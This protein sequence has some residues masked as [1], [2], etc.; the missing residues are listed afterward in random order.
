M[1]SSESSN[2]THD[3]HEC[4]AHEDSHESSAMYLAFAY[5]DLVLMII[6][7]IVLAGGLASIYLCKKQHNQNI[8]LAGLTSSEM[9]GA[10][11]GVL[12]ILLERNENACDVLITIRSLR[13][14]TFFGIV[15]T[16]YI[17]TIDR[18]VMVAAPH[19][20]KDVMTRRRTMVQVIV[21]MIVA[22]A[23][24]IIKSV[25]ES[26]ELVHILTNV[27]LAIAISYLIVAIGTYSF[28]AIKINRQQG[29][30]PSRLRFRKEFLMPLIIILTFVLFHAIPLAI[31]IYI[32]HYWEG[33]NV[34]K[35]SQHVW[36]GICSLGAGLGYISDVVTYVFLTPRYKSS[37]RRLCC[38]TTGTDATSRTSTSPSGAVSMGTIN[39]RFQSVEG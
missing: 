1:F 34:E 4:E 2:S 20:Y 30:S 13:T 23:L 36:Y 15:F 11:I 8:I 33:E 6:S 29:Q 3:H 10:L 18:L 7:V 17:L 26:H 39:S 21:V 9:F 24:G 16:M 25:L 37:L 5:L 27:L 32:Y 14:I 28:I 31:L 22:I 19:R 35:R 12:D 38:R